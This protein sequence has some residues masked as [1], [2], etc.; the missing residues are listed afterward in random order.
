MD[1]AER[2]EYLQIVTKK[3][4]V[5][6]IVAVIS[7]GIGGYAARLLNSTFLGPIVFVFGLVGGFVSIQQR[8]PS[9]EGDELKMLSKSWYFVLL[10]PVNGGIFAVVLMLMF[11]SG[12]V[13]GAMFPTFKQFLFDTGNPLKLKESI[14][15]WFQYSLPV[16]GPD[17]GKL[18]FWSFVAGF[19]ERFVPQIIRTTASKAASERNDI[20]FQPDSKKS[21][22]A[23]EHDSSM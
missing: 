4:V 12:L 22:R 20:Q 7:L 2:Q 10:I 11:L 6:T 8:L 13:E 5:I 23:S 21:P 1:N 17:L 14:Q 16:S 18:L 19:S 3:L 15:I 9:I